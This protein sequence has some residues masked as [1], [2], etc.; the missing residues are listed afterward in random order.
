VLSGF[1]DNWMAGQFDT[2][3]SRWVYRHRWPHLILRRWVWFW[4]ANRLDEP[5]GWR[6][7]FHPGNRDL[8]YGLDVTRCGIV[9]F[10]AGQGAADLAP[11]IC[12]GDEAITRFLPPGVEFRRTQVIA[13]GA[14]YCDF[15]YHNVPAPPRQDV[16]A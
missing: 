1:V 6:F 9:A 15:R 5:A 2:A 16:P 3:V 7:R 14:P 10:L 11:L 4:T 13:Q 12:R 8:F